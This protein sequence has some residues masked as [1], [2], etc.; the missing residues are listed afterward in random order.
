M[1]LAFAVARVR[2]HFERVVQVDVIDAAEFRAGR[3]QLELAQP[4][5]VQVDWALRVVAWQF[6][7]DQLKSVLTVCV[8]ND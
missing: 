5:L 6:D 1:L 8:S 2:H 7:S 4:Y 3:E